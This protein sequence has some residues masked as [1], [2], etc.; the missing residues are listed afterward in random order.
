MPRPKPEQPLQQVI[1]RMPEDLHNRIKE[2]A[3]HNDLSMAQAVR[4]AVRMYV[5]AA[6]LQAVG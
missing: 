3:A 4:R 1:I 6:D 5:E 2:I